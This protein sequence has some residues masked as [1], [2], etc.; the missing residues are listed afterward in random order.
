MRGLEARV[1][2]ALHVVFFGLGLTAQAA[3]ALL[4]A[5][6]Y[7]YEEGRNAWREEGSALPLLIADD[8][9]LTQA[10]L[11]GTRFHS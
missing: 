8:C 6:A 3:Q 10:Y 5:Q 9:Q 4:A 7:A 2:M 1:Q 11:D